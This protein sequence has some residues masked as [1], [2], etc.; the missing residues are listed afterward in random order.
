MRNVVATKNGISECGRP[1][2]TLLVGEAALSK[3]E[4]KCPMDENGIVTNWDDMERVWHH[5]FYNELRVAPEEH[6]VL[7]TESLFNPEENR[8]KMTQIMFETFNV[9]AMYVETQAKLSLY[10]SGRSTGVVVR[11][12]NGV[13]NA[14]PIHEGVM[15]QSGVSAL[16]VGGKYLTDY[17]IKMLEGRGYSLTTS[18]ER[19]IARD[20]K[21]KMCYVA[22]DFHEEMAKA[23]STRDIEKIY[24]LPDGEVISA[25]NERFRCPEA[26][27][28]PSMIDVD[29]PG[30]HEL[31][32]NSIMN[33]PV[34][35]QGLLYCNIILSGGSSI[36]EGIKERL[37]KEIYG[38]LAPPYQPV[39]VIASP[40]RKYSSWIGGSIVGSLSNFKGNWITLDEYDKNGPST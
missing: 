35:I 40:E 29:S 4:K 33:C 20:I 1:H 9:P 15:I 36:F 37:E 7:L 16:D 10:A 21:E 6:P 26:L 24:E 2:Q 11:C 31:I 23:A 19:E 25:G 22:L 13:I 32:N 28:Q 17:M 18:S 38:L 8:E 30:I 12:G 27:F 39:K 14:V 34:D 3:K 5:I